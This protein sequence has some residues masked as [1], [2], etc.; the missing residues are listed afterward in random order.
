[1][2]VVILLFFCWFGDIRLS[3]PVICS[4][5]KKAHKYDRN[6]C[7]EYS[8]RMELYWMGCSTCLGIG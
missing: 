3:S 8:C 1:M 6:L 4:I 5:A 2:D 7:I